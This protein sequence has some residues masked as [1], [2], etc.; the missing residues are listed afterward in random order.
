MTQGYLVYPTLF[1]I[2][3]DAI[4]RATLQDICGPQKAQHGFGWSAGEHKICFYADNGRIAGQYLIWVQA[5]LTTIVRMFERVG[6]Q[7]NL[8]KTKAMMCTTGFIWVQQG[9]EAYKRRSAGEGPTFRESKIIRV[10]CKVCGET[11]AASSLQ[12]HMDRAHGR[13]LPQVRGVDVGGVG[14]E[15]YKVSFPRIIKSVDCP[16]EGC[17]AK[18]K[19]LG[20]LREHFMFRHWKFKVTILQEGPEPLPRC[21]Q[22][23]M[24][25]QAARLFKHWQSDKFHK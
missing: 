24:H 6:F 8:N 22:C 25:M 13:L 5:A 7:T 21:D 3:V 2:I 10:S 17:P 16:V 20:R 4:V 9:D 14:L 11:M 18:A 15:I 19:T 12:H 23:G 1:N